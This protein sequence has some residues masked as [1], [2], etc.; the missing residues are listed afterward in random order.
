M[1]CSALCYLEADLKAAD[2][3]FGLPSLELDL[4]SHLMCSS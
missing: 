1:C 4:A 2:K 3:P